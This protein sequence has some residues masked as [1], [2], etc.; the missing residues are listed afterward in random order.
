MM[1]VTKNNILNGFINLYQPKKGFRVGIDSILLASSVSSYD[2]CL[3]L[4]TGTGI[5]TLSLAKRFPLSKIIAIEK[6]KELIKIAKKNIILNNLKDLNIQMI[7][8]DLKK[9]SFLA[10]LNNTFD[11]VVMNPPYF[12]KENFLLSLNNNKMDSKYEDGIYLWF[13][14]AYKKLKPKGYLNFIYRSEY[15]DMIMQYLNKDWGDIRIFPL[16]AKKGLPSKLII[17]QAKKKSK[18]EVKLLSG[19]VLH[20]DDGTY[21]EDCN[22]ILMN[23][24]NIDLN[25]Y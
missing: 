22:S 18:S 4:G 6:N 14:A 25:K 3:E 24:S 15:L 10:D 7:Y 12:N 8:D 11:R 19:L 20:N 13:S 17:V 1:E 2:N 9:D 21:T 16:W 23:T 5:V